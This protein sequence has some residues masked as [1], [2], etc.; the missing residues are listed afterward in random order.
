VSLTLADLITPDTEDEILTFLLTTLGSNSFPVTDWEENGVAMTLLSTF[1]KGELDSVNKVSEIAKGGFLGLAAGDWLKLKAASDFSNDFYPAVFAKVHIRLTCAS[2]SG[3]YTITPAQLWISVN[4]RRY[5]SANAANVVL[6]TGSP[7]D[8]DFVAENAGMLFNISGLG[9]AVTMLTPLPGVTAALQE[10]SG[11]SGTAMTIQGI[12]EESDVALTQRC[13]AKWATIAYGS[14]DLA[15]VSWARENQ[16]VTKVRVRSN[17]P[18]GPGTLRVYLAGPNG[19]VAGGVVTDV[20]AVIQ[21]RKPNCSIVAT[22][23][24]TNVAVNI[25]A[26]LDVTTGT[27]LASAEAQAEDALRAFFATL[28]IGDKVYRS[29]LIEAIMLPSGVINVV[30]A[31]PAGDT[32]IDGDV[33]EIGVLGTVTW[34]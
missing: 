5:N 28:E 6:A 16:N 18:D 22:I 26:H 13:R 17:N 34:T 32:A 8:I 29:A 31:T 24:A 10:T 21:V 12:D 19:G 14:T 3:P 30:L 23:T 9:A 15:Y 27:V 33:G 25:S 20:N 1:A 2:G 4:A 7:V 11:G